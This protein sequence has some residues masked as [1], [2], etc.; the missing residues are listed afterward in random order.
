ML[1]LGADGE[2]R[3]DLTFDPCSANID[4]LCPMRADVPIEAHGEITVS[5]ADVA[6]IPGES[7]PSCPRRGEMTGISS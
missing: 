6:N 3:F 5:A 1:T 4:N 7:P 2:S